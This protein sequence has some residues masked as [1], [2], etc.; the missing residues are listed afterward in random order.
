MAHLLKKAG[1]SFFALASVSAFGQL[2]NQGSF[3]KINSV[4]GLGTT[5]D[6]VNSPQAMSSPSSLSIS[7]YIEGT[8][9]NPRADETA[10]WDIGYAIRF[11]TN[12]TPVMLT[13]VGIA[14]NNGQVVNSGGPFMGATPKTTTQM[15]THVYELVGA[16]LLDTGYD[17]MTNPSTQTGNGINAFG[18]FSQDTYESY[19][20]RP[21]TTYALSIELVDTMVF[22]N[23][24][25]SPSQGVTNEF[26]ATGTHI[27]G[28]IS[29]TAA[30]EPGSLAVM[31]L[32]VVG[33]VLRRRR[34]KR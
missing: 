20:L 16:N 1:I 7:D 29:Y 17:Q 3:Q 23:T 2:I 12:A 6:V 13:S 10:T 4:M 24:A 32:G 28:S 26:N 15:I 27:T 18:S 25:N 11:T 8:Y 30:P 31:G 5:V 33:L 14:V 9:L 19:I 22:S 34:S 21:R